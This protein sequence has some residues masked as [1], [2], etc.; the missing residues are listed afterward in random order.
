MRYC[1]NCGEEV[2]EDSTKCL[3]CNRDLPKKT[4]V[5]GSCGKTDQKTMII[6]QKEYCE[7]CAKI[8]INSI[9]V[10]TTHSI[11]NTQIKEYLGVES[12]EVVIGTGLWSELT[13][14]FSDLFGQRST[15][16]ENKLNVAKKNTVLKLKTI[17]AM[18]GANA[19]IGMSLNYT[20]FSGN[21]IGVITAGTLVKVE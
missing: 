18:K 15:V 11:N 1:P 9:I 19:V 20:E 14:D 16:F 4:K 21:R 5:C 13:S 17:A 3:N 2:F 8:L 7:S 12:T 10:T 6:Y